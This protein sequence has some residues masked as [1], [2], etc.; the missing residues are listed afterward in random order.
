MAAVAH[1]EQ[2]MLTAEETAAALAAPTPLAFWR[3]KRGLTQK[4]LSLAVGVSQSY[5]ADLEAGRRKGDAAL[6]KRLARAL[7][8]RMEDLVADE[9]RE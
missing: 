7:R 6:V 9:A 1:G 5:V 4:E 8:L 2:D 3:V